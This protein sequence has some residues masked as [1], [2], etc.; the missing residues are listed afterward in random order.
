MLSKLLSNSNLLNYLL[1]II[2]FFI[3]IILIPSLGGGF[4]QIDFDTDTPTFAN[5]ARNLINLDLS[6]TKGLAIHAISE[7]GETVIDNKTQYS[8]YVDHPPTLYWLIVGAMK[9]FGINLFSAR[10]VSI[11]ASALIAIYIF[12]ILRKFQYSGIFSFFILIGTPL[13]IEHGLVPGY[14]SITLLFLTISIFYFSEFIDSKRNDKGFL[15]LSLIFWFLSLISDWPAYFL[16]IPL[17]FYF[18]KHKSIFYCAFSIVLPIITY[19]LL[20]GYDS[21]VVSGNFYNPLGR[22]ISLASSDP[23]QPLDVTIKNILKWFLRNYRFILIFFLI[24]LYLIKI[25]KIKL[26]NGNYFFIN[27]FIII[28]TLNIVIFYNWA[29]THSFWSYYY[30]PSIVFIASISIEIL[31]ERLRDFKYKNLFILMPL[32]IILIF[33]NLYNLNKLYSYKNIQFDED[34]KK[35][36][37]YSKSDKN[38]LLA[39]SEK[40]Y[41]WHGHVIKWYIDKRLSYYSSEL[42]EKIAEDPTKFMIVM[43]TAVFHQ[44]D[45]EIK[46]K[47]TKSKFFDVYYFQ[48]NNEFIESNNGLEDLKKLFVIID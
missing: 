37:N 10:L 47:F 13:Y 39:H 3:C 32:L 29:G 44:I 16:A 1:G 5:Y 25:Q 31:R 40:F 27:S 21:Y 38:K 48:L 15:F 41:W 9:I 36:I 4:T 35:F 23:V 43:R 33:S 28:G 22:L 7:T 18:F 11:V 6:I 26:S 45:E 42:D 24:G 34:T 8:W 14:Q 19:F 46:K 2:I 20:V 30:L 12:K 17:F